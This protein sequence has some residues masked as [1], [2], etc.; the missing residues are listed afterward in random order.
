MT[1]CSWDCCSPWPAL[2]DKKDAHYL[3]LKIVGSLFSLVNESWKSARPT[4]SWTSSVALHAWILLLY[5]LQLHLP[6]A[7]FSLSSRPEWDDGSLLHVLGKEPSDFTWLKPLPHPSSAHGDPHL[8]K[9]SI[10]AVVS[11]SVWI[12]AFAEMRDEI[13]ARILFSLLV[14]K[15]ILR[16][17]I[18][19]LLPC[20]CFRG[21]PVFWSWVGCHIGP[22]SLFNAVVSGWDISFERWRIWISTG[23]EFEFSSYSKA[24]FPA[25]ER[26]YSHPFH[27]NWLYL[28]NQPWSICN[29]LVRTSFFLLVF[30]MICWIQLPGGWPRKF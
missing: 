15:L 13:P 17:W 11:S 1:Y 18:P 14:I 10:F 8:E 4:D 28:K 25:G 19:T 7:L 21:G 5:L 30:C 9:P 12:A 27:T 6:I 16:V 20:C 26:G 3:V 2:L 24:N 22:V 23:C 29:L